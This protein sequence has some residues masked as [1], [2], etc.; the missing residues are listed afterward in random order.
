MK[1]LSINKN[2]GSEFNQK[3]MPKIY[4]K[5]LKTEINKKQYIPIMV[6]VKEKFN[7]TK[8]EVLNCIKIENLVVSQ[9][10]DTYV[11]RF[12]DIMIKAGVPFEQIVD[13]IN[14][15]DVSFRGCNLFNNIVNYIN[16]NI[17]TINRYYLM[18]GQ[19]DGS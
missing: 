6:K 19:I 11:V 12:N 18:G 5:L 4:I 10:E 9:V 13:Y 15:G 8:Q 3:Y 7:I 1:T 17:R 14:D 16:G 2:F